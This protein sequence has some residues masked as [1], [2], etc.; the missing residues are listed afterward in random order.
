MDTKAFYIKTLQD[1]VNCTDKE[2]IDNFLADFKEWILVC[3]KM[4][5]ITNINKDML[6]QFKW[7][8]DKQV[9]L[10]FQFHFNIK[11]EKF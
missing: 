6:Y 4:Q 3:K 10:I 5:N 2:N 11:D 9:E 7:V 8:D 1:I